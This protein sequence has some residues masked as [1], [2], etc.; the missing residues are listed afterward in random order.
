MHLTDALDIISN[1]SIPCAERIRTALSVGLE[2]RNHCEA[3][4]HASI[5]L[6]RL[7]FLRLADEPGCSATERELFIEQADALL[8]IPF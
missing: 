2:P 1:P 5:E 3:L 4:T 6:D 7:R 8:S